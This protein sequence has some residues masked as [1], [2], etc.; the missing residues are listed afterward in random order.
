VITRL[1]LQALAV[2]SFCAGSPAPAAVAPD[3]YA[4]PRLL[5]EPADLRKALDGGEVIVLDARKREEFE[6][7]RVPTA[8]WVD[9]AAWTRDFGHGEDAK[10]WSARIAALGIGSRS[11][12]VLYDDAQFKDAAR[13]WW[14][15]RYFGLEDAALLNGDWAGWKAA[16]F[17]IEAGPAKPP[18]EGKFEARPQPGRLTTRS[19]L[20]DSLKSGRK[21]QVIDARSEAEYC[22]TDAQKNKRA[23]AIPGAVNLEWIDL[24]DRPTQR[25]K[26]PGE[27]KKLFIDAGIDI[28][29]PA[30]THCQ[31]GGRSSV[32]VFGLELLGA[33]Q[34]SNYYAS[35]AEWGNSDDTP[36]APGKPKPKK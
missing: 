10:G 17:P 21:L 26:P 32:M 29:K 19:M 18:P 5:I 30:V 2:V 34:V 15:L 24:I 14:I 9:A 36:V 25:F 22:G 33:D 23:G 4:R 8:R 12:V 1:L 31:S 35:W 20:L 3:A 7:G 16:T 27:L 6:K 13:L 11:R 28:S